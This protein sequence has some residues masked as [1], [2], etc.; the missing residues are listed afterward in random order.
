MRVREDYRSL[1]GP[2]KA[3]ILM[4]SLGEEHAA[5]L[6]EL[7]DDEEIREVSQTMAN[8]GTASANIIERL[9][10]KFAE[11]FSQGGSLVGSMNSTDR[12]L[13]K[14]LD[15]ELIHTIME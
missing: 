10:V 8:L 6:F 15:K 14:V 7:M 5:R 13:N 9:F 11:Q 12:L 4:M 2:E 3:A 1:T